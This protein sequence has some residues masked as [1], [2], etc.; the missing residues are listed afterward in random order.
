MA[1]G[2]STYRQRDLAVARKVAREGDRVEVRRDGTIAL[3]VGGNAAK[4]AESNGS[5]KEIATA[6][7]GD[8]DNI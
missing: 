1:R 8:W 2:K 4:P 3:I 7:E 6:G 5:T